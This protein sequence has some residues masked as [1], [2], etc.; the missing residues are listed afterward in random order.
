M[1]IFLHHLNSP[2][3]VVEWLT[4]LIFILEVP[5]S[6]LCPEIGYP[7]AFRDFTQSL[8]ENFGIVP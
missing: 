6:T 8:Q 7:E 2:N 1:L 5:G 3:V 4:L